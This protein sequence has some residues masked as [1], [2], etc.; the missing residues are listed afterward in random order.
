MEKKLGSINVDLFVARGEEIYHE[1]K[2]KLEPQY[3]GKIVA[4]DIDTGDYFLGESV[5]KAVKEGRKK[6]P[7]K[8]F[9][10]VKIG[11]KTVHTHK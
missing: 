10:T 6:Y 8:V 11:Y 5:V 9:H 4:I 3:K 7:H 2:D 1:I